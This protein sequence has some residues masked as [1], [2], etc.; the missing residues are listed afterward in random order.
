MLESHSNEAAIPVPS[1]QKGN[2]VW[3][4]YVDGDGAWRWQQLGTDSKLLGESPASHTT[5]EVCV[6]D[7]EVH[8]YHYAPSQAKIAQ[9]G[10]TSAYVRDR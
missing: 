2:F 9:P 1:V 4:F 10:R 7:A 6:A 8:G 5:Y 3:R